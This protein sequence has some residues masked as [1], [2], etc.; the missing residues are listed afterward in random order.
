M[1]TR[2][3]MLKSMASEIPVIAQKKSPIPMSTMSFT[4]QTWTCRPKKKQKCQHIASKKDKRIGGTEMEG[5]QRIR[6]KGNEEKRKN[7]IPAL[8]KDIMVHLT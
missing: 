1:G 5:I 3:Y 7:S 8:S 4:L 2:N 6:E